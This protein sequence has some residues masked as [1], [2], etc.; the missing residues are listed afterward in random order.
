ME[1]ITQMYSKFGWHLK[2][3]LMKK[4][5]LKNARDKKRPVL[6]FGCYGSQIEDAMAWA[7]KTKVLIW[8]SGSDITYC[9]RGREN[10]I[11]IVRN[12][13]NISHIATVSFIEKDLQKLGF[14][15][16]KVPLFSQFVDDFKPCKLGDKIYAYKPRLYVGKAQFEKMTTTFGEDA[17]ITAGSH[18]QFSQ[19]ELKGVYGRSILGIRMLTHDGLGHTVCEMG[20][21]GR[22]VIYNGDT[23]NAINYVSV[24]DAIEKIKQCQREKYDPYA[25]ARQMYNYLNV[26]DDWLNI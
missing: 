11:T 14:N 12:H 26:G 17:F 15:Y 3:N 22:K 9:F 18:H 24:S 10:L 25:V 8:W 13:P 16:K 20:L 1:K 23:P 5:N 2:A 19:E 21:M 6:F 4:Y 7:E